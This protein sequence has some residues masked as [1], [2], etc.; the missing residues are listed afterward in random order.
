MRVPSLAFALVLILSAGAP[1][2]ADSPMAVAPADRHFGPAKMSFLD[3]RSSIDALSTRADEHPADARELYHEAVLVDDALHDWQAHYPRDPW[4]P[5]YVYT[6]AQVYGK[7]DARSRR[8]RTLDWLVRAYPNSE[9][10]ELP[11]D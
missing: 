2:L 7:L 5:A 8:D 1:A 4:I 6:L 11:R 3:V 10:A 9:F